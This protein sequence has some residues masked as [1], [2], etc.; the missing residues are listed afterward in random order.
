MEKISVY[1]LFVFRVSAGMISCNKDGDSR[2]SGKPVNFSYE[3][4]ELS[5]LS[6]GQTDLKIAD[7]SDCTGFKREENRKITV[8][9]GGE[10]AVDIFYVREIES[11]ADNFPVKITDA[12]IY[13]YD[14][15]LDPDVCI[16]NRTKSE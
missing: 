11:D 13:Q 6:I 7:G 1:S 8:E 12:G 15:A 5:G 3:D 16:K 10:P 4:N 2:L 9:S 14:N